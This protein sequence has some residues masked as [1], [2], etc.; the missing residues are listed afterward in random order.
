MIVKNCLNQVKH[1]VYRND[2][3]KNIE[4]SIS[5]VGQKKLSEY[6]E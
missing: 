2:T 6:A 1:K 4:T 5:K 3:A